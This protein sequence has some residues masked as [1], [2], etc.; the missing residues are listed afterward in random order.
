MGVGGGVAFTNPELYAAEITPP[1]Q[2]ALTCAFPEICVNV[3]ILLGYIVGFALGDNWRAM[4]GIG[5]GLPALVLL[6]QLAVLP[7]SPRWLV[8]RGRT[9]EAAAILD[10]ACLASPSDRDTILAEIAHSIEIEKAAV[11]GTHP[12]RQVLCAT[13]RWIRRAMLVGWGIAVFQQLTG[14]EGLVYFT[15]TIFQTLGVT[16]D[17]AV[18]CATAAVG[19]CKAL[20]V[21][22]PLF[23]ADKLGRKPLLLASALGMTASL[24]VLGLMNLHLTPDGSPDTS[25]P[26]R[27]GL[28]V[29]FLCIFLAFFSIGFGPL[30]GVYLPEVFPLRVRAVGVGVGWA[31]NR[32]TSGIVALT[33]L[34]LAHAASV[35]GAFLV[36]FGAGVAATVFVVLAVPETKGLSMEQV[37]GL[38]ADPRPMLSW[39]WRRDAVVEE[40]GE[41]VGRGAAGRA[42]EIDDEVEPDW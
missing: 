1:K 40:M 2:R 36:Y 37:S 17:A 25:E 27:D 3:G 31:L 29:F 15:P 21:L 16:S 33:F 24:L 26:V 18:L 20:F 28:T 22:F 41:D 10:A 42:E 7:E 35:G 30:T 38:M 14:T 23:L 34:P 39:K 32:L 5:A 12:W 13:S 9:P 4:M 8:K 11:Q 19:L 6:L